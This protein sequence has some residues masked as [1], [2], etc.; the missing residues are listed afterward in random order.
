MT[1][2]ANA[3]KIQE[4]IAKVWSDESLKTQLLD[5]PKSVW[6]NMG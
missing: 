5:N 2:I 3:Q 6:L 4:I 1:T